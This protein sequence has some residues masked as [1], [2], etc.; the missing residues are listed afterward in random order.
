[1]NSNEKLVSYLEDMEGNVSLNGEVYISLDNMCHIVKYIEINKEVPNILLT[2]YLV[3]SESETVYELLYHDFNIEVKAGAK[4]ICHYLEGNTLS[5][6]INLNLKPGI[7]SDKSYCE[8]ASEQ[9]SLYLVA[10]SKFEFS[11]ERLAYAELSNAKIY[12]Q[13]F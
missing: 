4:D 9:I 12:F 1:M 3:N 2:P 13:I 8:F 7:V 10:I 5:E 11:N 6:E